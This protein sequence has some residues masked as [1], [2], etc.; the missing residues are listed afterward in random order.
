MRVVVRS[1]DPVRQVLRETG[2]RL[3]IDVAMLVVAPVLLAM[4]ITHG[5][6]AW[7]VR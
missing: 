2:I 3:L 4:A 1:N 6:S 5:M 7:G